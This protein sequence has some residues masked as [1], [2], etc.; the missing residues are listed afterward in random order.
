M[1][2]NLMQGFKF[3]RLTSVFSAP[4]KLDSLFGE[5]LW[6]LSPL[7]FLW[8][9]SIAI[10]HH[11]A[12]QIANQPYD[13]ALAENVRTIAHQV[14][15]IDGRIVVNLPAPTRAFLRTEENHDT[16][17][18]VTGLRGELLVGDKELPKA[19][20]PET[21]APGAV[22]FRDDEI[23]GK[24]IRVAYQFISL[25][26]QTKPVLV[27]VA[28][29]LKKREY[30][31][32]QII[33]GV[34]LPQFAIVPLA[35]V[36]VYIGLTRGIAPLTR[37]QRHIR[38]RR[39]GNLAPISIYGVPEEVRPVIASFNDMMARLEQNLHAQQRFITD[40]AHQMRTPLTGLKMQTELAL[41][42]SD[43][44][45]IR[46]SLQQIA[47]SA[48]R[49]IH[50]I[51][52]LLLLARAEAGHEKLY[53]F[54]TVDLEALARDVTQ[55]A[56]PRALAKDI[57]LGFEDSG[58]PLL[59]DGSPVLLRELMSNLID[60]AIKYTPRYGRVT[61]RTCAESF[62]IFEVEDNGC[63]IAET[64]RELVFERFYRVLGSEADGSGLGLSIVREIAEL[65]RASVL[66]RP[67][68]SGQ[69]TV[70]RAVF[71]R[72]SAFYPKSPES[73][74]ELIEI[75]ASSKNDHVLQPP[76]QTN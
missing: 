48:E 37:L 41:S 42:E 38:N 24:E 14:K 58:W 21:F 12:N 72:Q 60:N 57:D 64:D 56:V 31:A 19:E 71:P 44:R 76:P 5:I 16:F 75:V 39:P 49:A 47:E 7:L 30:L 35:V 43:P 3:T 15:L 50:L 20:I 45:L 29:T 13:E 11:F 10:T 6:M 32:S 8:P 27:Q 65:H 73:E 53:A 25:K 74:S 68:P 51:N 55:E 33:S 34:I 40:A 54:E 2:R 46:K 62:A 28:E 9:I 22:L 67:N 70:A 17:Y 52:Q 18:Q 61:V 26:P 63:G 66:L 4:R 69:G 23:L 59:I 1:P 36:L